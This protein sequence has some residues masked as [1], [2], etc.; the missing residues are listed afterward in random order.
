VQDWVDIL[1]AFD[2]FD[3][4]AKFGLAVSLTDGIAKKLMTAVADPVPQSF[5]GLEV[6]A[7][8]SVIIA[9]I[10]RQCLV[11]WDDMLRAAGGRELLRQDSAEAETT[12]GMTPLYEYTW[13][14][15][16]LH[17]LRGDKTITYLQCL[18]PADRALELVAK[19]NAD[20][21]DELIQHLEFQ[22]V[23]GRVTCSSL[24]IIR[25]TTAERLAEIVA[26]H[27]ASGVMIANPHF[28]TLEDGAG[29]KRVGAD[30]PAMKARMDPYALLNPGKMRSYQ[31]S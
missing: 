14:H 29:H 30:Q 17:M 7:G 11:A 31:P 22:R 25:F 4:A 5:R 3:S 13:N 2:D 6:P 10:A 16:T 15:T 19:I 21:P 20:F 28:Y 8:K 9:M 1:V 26:H 27:E 18:F 23:G 12:P 24:P